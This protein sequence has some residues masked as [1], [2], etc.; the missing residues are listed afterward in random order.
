MMLP[1]EDLRELAHPVSEEKMLKVILTGSGAIFEFIYLLEPPL[2]KSLK[3]ITKWRG[4]SFYHK[5]NQLGSFQKNKNK[6]T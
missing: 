3:I 1:N 2:G 5:M 6:E 4:F